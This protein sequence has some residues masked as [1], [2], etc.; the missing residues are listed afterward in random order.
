MDEMKPTRKQRLSLGCLQ[1]GCVL[2]VCLLELFFMSPVG[3]QHGEAWAGVNHLLAVPGVAFLLLAMARGGNK[4]GKA[5]GALSIAMLLWFGCVQFFRAIRGME[6]LLPGEITCFYALALPMA[7]A[8]E[9]GQRQWGLKALTLTF[10]AESLALTVLGLSLR[11]G[12][13]PEAYAGGVRWDGTRLL[14][15]FH[16]NN[17]AVVL[18]LGIGIC[19]GLCCR[20]KKVWFRAILVVLALAQFGVQIMN[21]GRTGT[22]ATCLLVG[23]ILFCAIRKTGWKRAPLALAAAV[24]V[25]VMM[26]L[27]AQ[28]LY[29]LH[30]SNL[31][32]AALQAAQERVEAAAPTVT[33]TTAETATETTEETVPETTAETIP[34]VITET[35]AEVITEAAAETKPTLSYLPE[36]KEDGTLD[37]TSVQKDLRQDLLSLN[38][39]TAIWKAA[40][41]GVKGDVKLLVSGTDDPGVILAENGVPFALHTHNS[42]LE[43]LYTLGLPGLLIALAVTLLALRGAVLLLWRNEDLWKSAV[44]M[45]ALCLLACGML[46]PYLFV[47]GSNQNYITLFFLTLAGYLHQWTVEERK[48]G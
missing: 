7:W 27:C 28:G 41:Q 17:C 21:H 5:M 36:V 40:I 48:A 8:M 42:F 44:A 10:L 19:L 45:L 18:M 33:E 39:R 11:F 12:F 16:P 25:M 43:V 37:T 34:K 32:K 47:S 15:L 9:D 30:E 20:S 14:E 2:L 6:Q 1:L 24:G 38:G 13:L 26:Y 46:E 31:T 29:A 35:T 22:V 23:G 3:R 4:P